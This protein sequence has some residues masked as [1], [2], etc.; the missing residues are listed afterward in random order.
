M[1]CVSPPLSLVT[2]GRTGTQRGQW[3]ANS[4]D[5]WMCL[6]IYPIKTFMG[7]CRLGIHIWGRRRGR[8][9]GKERETLFLTGLFTLPNKSLPPFLSKLTLYFLVLIKIT[10]AEK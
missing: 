2:L 8:G 7:R 1:N 10:R 4:E 5:N 3:D 6:L 9:G